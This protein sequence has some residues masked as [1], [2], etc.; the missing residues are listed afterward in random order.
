MNKDIRIIHNLINWPVLSFTKAMQGHSC[1]FTV[2]ILTWK[3]GHVCVKILS[4]VICSS[5]FRS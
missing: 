4:I 2:K 5:I 3:N 1:L